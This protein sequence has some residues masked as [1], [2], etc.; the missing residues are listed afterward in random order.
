[1]SLLLQTSAETFNYMVMGYAFILGILSLYLV[2]IVL[3][4]RKLK[5]EMELLKEVEVED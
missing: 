3:R 5:Q 2:S 4:Y 1:M